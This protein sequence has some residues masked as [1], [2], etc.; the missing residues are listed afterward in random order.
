MLKPSALTL[1]L[2]LALVLMLSGCSSVPTGDDDDAVVSPAPRTDLTFESEDGGHTTF[3]NCLSVPVVFAEGHGLTGEEVDV[4]TGLRGTQGEESFGSP[5][6]DITF[7]DGFHVYQNPSANEWQAD[8]ANGMSWGG[9]VPVEIDWSDNLIRHTW[10]ER[11]KIRVEA[12][13]TTAIEPGNHNLR[14]YNM[15]SLGGS[16]LDEVFVTNTTRH[17]ATSATVYSNVARLKIEKLDAPG[18]APVLTVYDSPCFAGYFVDGRSDVFSAEVNMGG[19]CIYG[20]NWDVEAVPLAIK[21]GWYRL[22]FSL[23][24]YAGY[25]DTFG[26]SYGYPRNTLITDINPDD[27]AGVTDPDMVLYS[28]TLS[29]NGRFSE[30]EIFIESKDPGGRPIR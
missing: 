1:A 19:K 28:P 22:T 14:G 2:I 29:E 9:E 20:Y 24:S 21:T 7:I 15:Y 12:V 3:G 13:L 30:L 17:I 4:F 8:W 10:T 26:K 18:G 25:T 16:K 5:Y 27:L 6:D 23:D 11:S